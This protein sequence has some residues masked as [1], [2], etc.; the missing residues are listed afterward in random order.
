MRAYSFSGSP[1]DGCSD[2]M[3]AGDRKETKPEVEDGEG[4]SE[5]W[6]V[7]FRISPRGGYS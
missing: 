1:G 6:K 3:L 7:T 2:F 4:V 5:G